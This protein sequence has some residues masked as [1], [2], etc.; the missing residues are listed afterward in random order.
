M[1]IRMASSLAR[2]FISST[3]SGVIE[4]ERLG[5]GAGAGVG[6]GALG[7]ICSSIYVTKTF[8]TD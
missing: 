4:V 6:A 3:I 1:V 5:A 2:A 7:A 8:L